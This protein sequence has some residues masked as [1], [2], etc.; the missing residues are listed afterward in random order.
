[1]RALRVLL[2]GV[3]NVVPSAKELRLFGERKV[4]L[5]LLRS[6]LTVLAPPS[7]ER[8][9]SI[10]AEHFRCGSTV[11][12]RNVMAASFAIFAQLKP[13]GDYRRTHDVA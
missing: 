7:R 6:A 2:V 5:A 9:V 1:M 4:L 13:S 8:H 11:G 12:T 10:H 3:G